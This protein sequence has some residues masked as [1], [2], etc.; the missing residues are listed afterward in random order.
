[1]NTL[2]WIIQIF[3]ASVFFC[4]GL[5]KSMHSEQKLVV[6]GQTGVEHLS[7]PFIRFIGI[8]ELAGVVGLILPEWFQC[9]RVL[10][11]LA[12]LCLG[13]IVLKPSGSVRCP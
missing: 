11:P 7:L 9:W 2:L 12:A 1:M 10:T 5:M 4:S 6:M 13:L 8:S 3:L